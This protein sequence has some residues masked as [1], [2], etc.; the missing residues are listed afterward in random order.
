MITFILYKKNKKNN[1]SILSSHRQRYQNN[2]CSANSAIQNGKFSSLCR[3]SIAIVV[4]SIISVQIYKNLWFYY[5]TTGSNIQSNILRNTSYNRTSLLGNYAKY[6]EHLSRMYFYS[7]LS[8]IAFNP[9]SHVFTKNNTITSRGLP[10]PS[11][12]LNSYFYSIFL[13]PAMTY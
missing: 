4:Y 12:S 10:N 13:S 3:S 9:S 1:T 6:R 2:Y 5:I 7:S 11:I 8:S